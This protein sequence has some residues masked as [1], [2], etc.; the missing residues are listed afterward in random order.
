MYTLKLNNEVVVSYET[1]AELSCKLSE[2][3]GCPVALGNDWAEVDL[4]N[5]LNVSGYSIVEE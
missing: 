4:N 1:K 3:A 2:I 5:I